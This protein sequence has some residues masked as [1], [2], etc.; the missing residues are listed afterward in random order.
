ML[1][2]KLLAAVL[3]NNVSVSYPSGLGIARNTYIATNGSN[4]NLCAPRS[5]ASF[6]LTGIGSVSHGSTLVHDMCI[7]LQIGV[8]AE[9]NRDGSAAEGTARSDAIGL[10]RVELGT[11]VSIWSE[12]V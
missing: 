3:I 4:Q 10:C 2:T 8:L 5:S 7:H 11:V 9:G 1:G 6:S 12:M